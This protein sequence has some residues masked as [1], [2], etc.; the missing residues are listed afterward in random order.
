MAQRDERRSEKPHRPAHFR[1]QRP[2]SR[3]TVTDP[4]R[5]VESRFG[6]ATGAAHHAVSDGNSYTMSLTKIAL[7]TR[8]APAQM[9]M[10]NVSHAVR[11]RHIVRCSTVIL[12]SSR[13]SRR[14]A[15]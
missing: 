3:G 2:F 13:K 4:L 15:Q 5:L 14:A 6:L 10:P 9:K 7:M 1:L 12:R 8:I 11:I